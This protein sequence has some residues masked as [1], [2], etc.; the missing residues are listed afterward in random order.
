MFVCVRIG[1][2][3]NVR[4]IYY[5][6]RTTFPD[7]LAKPVKRILANGFFRSLVFILFYFFFEGGRGENP[8]RNV[9]FVTALVM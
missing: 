2:R 8:F 1:T 9:A 6:D 5:N 7:R 3:M 4:V